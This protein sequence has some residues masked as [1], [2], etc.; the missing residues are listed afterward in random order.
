MN[1]SIENMNLVLVFLILA[2]SGF[3]A[4]IFI[5][6]K[7][8][9]R[10]ASKILTYFMLTVFIFTLSYASY[11]YQI[12]GLLTLTKH[13]YLPSGF[14]II[15]VLYLYIKALT[16]NNVKFTNQE[17]LHFLPSVLILF[18]L[19]IISLFPVGDNI[20]IYISTGFN[21]LAL[22]EFSPDLFILYIV[23][24]V[25][26]MFQ[27]AFYFSLMILMLIKHRRNVKEFF[28]DTEGINLTWLIVFLI[29]YLLSAVSIISIEFIFD[30]QAMYFD[31]FYNLTVVILLLFLSFFGIKQND[32]YTIPLIKEKEDQKN[33][34]ESIIGEDI[35]VLSNINE[36]QYSKKELLF[37]DLIDLIEIQ[38][39]YLQHDLSL[40]TIAE[41]LGSNKNYISSIINDKLDKN[42]YQYVN[43]LRIQEAINIMND[44]ESQQYTIENISRLAGFKSKSSF[45][46]YFKEKTGNTPSEFKKNNLA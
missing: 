37:N 6:V 2:I 41:K 7:S 40:A 42:F 25:I 36:T 1:I 46:K 33:V 20:N 21:H 31:F 24:D 39:L 8:T 43:D 17:L 18:F 27:L 32:I 44:T 28:S 26:F 19:I 14:A 22:D 4:F 38:K 16:I 3:S 23:Y 34:I 5:T 13:L 11:L 45:N 15:P 29:A 10:K 30:L 12:D 9:Y 35:P